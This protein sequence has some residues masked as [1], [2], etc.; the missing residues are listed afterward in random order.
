MM[1]ATVKAAIK[2]K[3]IVLSSECDGLG[4]A[5]QGKKTC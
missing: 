2:K 3:P 5:N 1:T 4:D